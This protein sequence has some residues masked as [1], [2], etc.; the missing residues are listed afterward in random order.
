L[1]SS[2]FAQVPFLLSHYDKPYNSL[3]DWFFVL[4][5]DIGNTT[6]EQIPLG[7]RILD[8]L[9]QAVCVKA[10]GFSILPLAALSCGQSTLRGDDVRRCLCVAPVPFI[11][12]MYL[13]FTPDP[14]AMSVR[15]TNVYEEQSLGIFHE[16]EP[17]KELV[18]IQSLPQGFLF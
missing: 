6:I 2:E 17:N 11:S 18:L 14:I 9:M 1:A 12:T 16:E 3:I 5:L 13:I 7:A 10:A 4:I 15:S 8:G